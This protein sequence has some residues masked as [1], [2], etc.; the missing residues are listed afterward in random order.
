MKSSWQ[1]KPF[2][3][4]IEKIIYTKKVPRKEFLDFGKYPIVSQEI[5][6]I[7]GYWNNKKDL[8]KTDSSIIIFGDLVGRK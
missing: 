1:T 2:N 8:F 6:L 4:C 7:N 5:N 3:K